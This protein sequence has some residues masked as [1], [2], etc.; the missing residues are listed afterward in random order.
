MLVVR[1]NG[2][3]GGVVP[4]SVVARRCPLWS[5][6]RATSRSLAHAPLPSK[7]ERYASQVRSAS[8]KVRARRAWQG[9]GRAGLPWEEVLVRRF[10]SAYHGSEPPG[11]S[12]SSV[13]NTEGTGGA[14]PRTRR[15]D[16]RRMR[17]V[18]HDFSGHPFQAELSRALADRGHVVTHVHCASFPSGKGRVTPEGDS[19]N[20]RYEAIGLGAEFARYSPLRRL[21]QELVYGT[22]FARLVSHFQPDVVI[23]CNDPLFAKA[24]FGV[25]AHLR[26]QRW[27]FWLQDLYGLAMAR[28]A[29][30]GG[31][32][33]RA[34]G[35]LFQRVER[36]LLSHADGVVLIT[37]DF[38]PS[39][40][41]A[42]VPP[43]RRTV[44][45]NWAPLE[46][47]PI[48]PRENAWREAQGLGDRFLYLYSGTLGLKHDPD[49]LYH[50]AEEAVDAEVIVVSEGL[51]A[52]R[53]EDLQRSRRLPNLR[54]L[55]F[56]PY[57]DLPEVLA[58]ADVLVVLL[59]ASAGTFSVPSKVLTYL[60]AG[61]PILGS[62][63]F[64]N[65]ATRTIVDAG[66][67]IVAEPTD[68]NAFLAAAKRF[69]TDENERR[70][71]GR[72][73]RQYAESTFDR[74]AIAEAFDD[75]I[76]RAVGLGPCVKGA[77]S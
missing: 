37:E 29:A 12:S 17:L 23:S 11:P 59:E 51:G 19:P 67:G 38:H 24:V 72:R 41:K 71:F 31:Q 61:R 1:L 68:T 48:R 33:G 3:L 36:W 9:S 2:Q 54:V 63:P 45:K 7:V 39:L 20:M 50:L 21:G 25:W 58:A 75:A 43:G 4:A 44:I 22:R 16:A 57:E 66:A 70:Q 28:E 53:L 40:N 56:Q 55:P 10:S 34:L 73:A 42:G 77:A 49:L 27:V 52:S 46:E 8:C 5:V 65:L 6:L 69:R 30:G 47:L 26:G 13:G 15:E 64:A 60:C 74:N 32:A 62:M 76:A 14:R 18:V 35:A